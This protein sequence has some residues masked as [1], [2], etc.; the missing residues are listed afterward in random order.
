MRQMSLTVCLSCFQTINQSNESSKIGKQSNLKAFVWL[1]CLIVSLLQR[2]SAV[3]AGQ[4]WRL[5]TK[6][7][8]VCS[9]H[10][11]LKTFSY[12]YSTLGYLIYYTIILTSFCLRTVASSMQDRL[13][14]C[15]RSFKRLPNHLEMFPS[16][17]SN[18]FVAWSTSRRKACSFWP[19]SF[20][21]NSPCIPMPVM[22]NTVPH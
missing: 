13:D 15:G 4:N 1:V 10:L 17:C 3:A 2:Q 7:Y 16:P 6:H 11:I 12:Y 18:P 8:V 19:H 22:Q 20:F 14:S 9:V 5:N 21:Q